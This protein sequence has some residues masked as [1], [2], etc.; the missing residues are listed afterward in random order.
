MSWPVTVK[1]G[2]RRLRLL[3]VD[4][5]EPVRSMIAELLRH[6]GYEV[7]TA[8]SAEEALQLMELVRWDGLVLDVDLPDMSGV[9]LYSR[10]L[11]NS[12]SERLPV[13]FFTGRLNETLQLGLG[14]APWA[15]LMPKPCSG[16]QFLAALEQCLQANGEAAP[17][18]GE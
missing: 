9:E 12:C 16:Q 11:K 2:C 1:T 18:V 14:S 10:I 8:A 6:Q 17:A 7:E 5:I 3:V 15:R 13:L 4:D